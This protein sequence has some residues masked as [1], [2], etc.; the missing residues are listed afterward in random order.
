[1][2]KRFTPSSE[3]L[4]FIARVR[5]TW[6]MLRMWALGLLPRL[7]DAE[8]PDDLIQF[9]LLVAWRERERSL[10]LSQANWEHWLHSVLQN[11]A[12]N[13]RKRAEVFEQRLAKALASHETTSAFDADSLEQLNVVLA[14]LP[15]PLRRM[16]VTHYLDGKTWDELGQLYSMTPAAVR[17]RCERAIEEL[18]R[19][20]T[21]S[22]STAT[23]RR[24]HGSKLSK[25]H[26]LL[27]LTEELTM[28]IDLSAP[29]PVPSLLNLILCDGAHRDPGLGKWTLLGMFNAFNLNRFPATY[30]HMCLYV[31]VNGIAGQ[32][33]VRLQISPADRPDE[34]ILKMDLEV[35]SANARVVADLVV[36]LRNVTFTKAGEHVIQVFVNNQLVGE[37]LLMVNAA[38][39]N[40][41]S[42]RPVQKQLVDSN[43][44][45]A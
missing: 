31:A 44:A 17:K 42:A 7:V 21:A 32:V 5:D 4:A 26:H 19:Q 10:T 16:L 6:P 14:T 1:M 41:R 22:V 3:Q 25:K 38:A 13:L 27:S 33:P 24:D 40:G 36:P 18:R 9:A 34:P 29:A 28:T 39:T 12:Q 11:R 45:G 8:G 23:H 20:S 43:H 35:K 30:P 15:E 2:P 37:R